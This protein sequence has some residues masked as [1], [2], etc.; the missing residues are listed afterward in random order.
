MIRC[1][2]LQSGYSYKAPY[3][4][5]AFAISCNDLHLAVQRFIQNFYSICKC[6]CLQRLRITSDL[7][8]SGISSSA[9]NGIDNS[10]DF[11]SATEA[12][13]LII[14]TVKDNQTHGRQLPLCH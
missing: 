7:S 14:N 10:K 12:F 3:Y 4:I 13:S 11:F 9:C 1:R 8:I 2:Q 5:M 6:A